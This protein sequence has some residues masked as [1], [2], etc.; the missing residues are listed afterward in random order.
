MRTNILIAHAKNEEQLAEN[1]AVPLRAAGYLITHEGTLLVG[2]SVVAQSTKL[3]RQGGPL[4]ICGTTAALGSRWTR[5]LAEAA[6]RTP[7]VR[8][9]VVQ[10]DEDADV[11]TISLDETIADYW[12]D[13]N[14]ALDR[15]VASVVS[16]YP[17]DASRKSKLIEH[18]LEASYR[19]VAL[20][21]CDIID[22]ANLPEDDRHLASRELELRRLY[23][24]LRMEVQVS[25]V[26]NFSEDKWDEIERLRR[27]SFWGEVPSNERK[28]VSLGERLG[29]VKKLVVLGDPGSGKSTLLRWLAT[30]YLLRWQS[31]IDWKD[32]PDV[33]SLPDESWL[34]ILVRCRDLPAASVTLDSM[35][36]HSLRKSE[37]P[38][39][40]CEPLKI[41][42][43]DKLT[44][45]EAILLVDGLDEI[46]DPTARAN[47]AEQLSKIHHAIPKAP[48]VITSRIVGYREMGYRIGF[49]FEH[50]TVA[51]LT[52]SDKD[53]FARRWCELTERSGC[54]EAA[55]SLIGDIHSSDRIE[56]LTGNP[57]LLT[58]MALIKRKIGR[59]PQRRVDLYEKAVE[60]LLNWRSAIDASLDP[61]EALPQL[62]YLAYA[63]CDEG[64]QQIR[65][66]Q[67]IDLLRQLRDE[68]PHV[69]P[70]REHSPED[71][72][73]LLERRTGLLMQTG[74]I[75]HNGRGV[76]VYEF[77]HLT[78]QEYLAGMAIV[79]GHYRGRSKFSN[80]IDAVRPL[81]GKVGEGF[82]LDH[83]HDEFGGAENWREPLRL[84]IAASN[85]DLID[86]SV[87]AI[88]RK[89]SDESFSSQRA[90]AMLACLCLADEPNVSGSV[91][92]EV[93]ET[94]V[95]VV[96]EDYKLSEEDGGLIN[97]S[98]SVARSR[99]ASDFSD[100]LLNG[101]FYG[102]SE[103]RYA[104]GG[105]FSL[106]EEARL[107]DYKQEDLRLEVFRKRILELPDLDGRK[108]AGLALLISEI[109]YSN[110]LDLS[111]FPVLGSE[112]VSRLSSD[113]AVNFALSWAVGWIHANTSWEPTGEDV[114]VM[115]DLLK[116]GC[117]E[118]ET[119][120][121][122]ARVLKGESDERVADA[123]EGYVD[124]GGAKVKAAIFS[125][126]ATIRGEH[127]LPLFRKHLL[128]KDSDIWRGALSAIAECCT[129]SEHKKLLMLIVENKRANRLSVTKRM[130]ML[131]ADKLDKTMLEVQALYAEISQLYGFSLAI[132]KG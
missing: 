68:F 8:I 37:I 16:Q 4:V 3:L 124:A 74:F 82:G 122:L 107:P 25:S 100:H 96:L 110:T 65:E 95:D 83:G 114:R 39:G 54:L 78:L 101:F 47:F 31:E 75:K 63:M 45:G 123:L 120:F 73:A 49:G 10:I 64:I 41:L 102:G 86:D 76:P 5:K 38:E 61:R 12:R 62:E 129:D 26:K 80:Q 112:L 77:R 35:L 127:Y 29:D 108:L 88:L 58:T 57:M 116:S 131:A 9:F 66:D 34:P 111:G 44:K 90:R 42:L 19:Q 109:A 20:R 46:T 118:V 106:V 51:D 87:L 13:P 89:E 93:F 70:L 115:L 72:L 119:V 30:A 104:C 32:I 81:A 6:R 128:A 28:L 121:W 98:L 43:R 7:G 84:C 117:C 67:A 1:L 23:V 48:V 125:A 18:D 56:R 24:A 85:D 92:Q 113:P 17:L 11:E 103:Y 21:A 50:L 27:R 40:N 33:E 126:L 53:E 105:M 130:L 99:W 22:L 69:H 132:Y 97:V 59:L 52:R 79:Q 55:N 60:V 71:F 15:L 2:E 14:A 91:V 94:Y 36:L